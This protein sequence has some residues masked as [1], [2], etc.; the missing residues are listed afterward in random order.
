MKREHLITN[1]CEI[2]ACDID[3]K[4]IIFAQKGI[5]AKETLKNIS[6]A[7]LLQNFIQ[8]DSDHYRIKPAI[9]NYI[10]FYEQDLLKPLCLTGIDLVVCRNFLI[11]ISKENQKIVINNL[12]KCMNVNAFLMLGKTEGFPLL[13]TSL[14]TPKNLR[15]HIYQ[16]SPH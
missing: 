16:Y 1:P 14:F 4:V 13:S 7:S 15:E 11:Y 8:L 3:S 5:Y 9:R 10:Q 6:A 12:I 2:L